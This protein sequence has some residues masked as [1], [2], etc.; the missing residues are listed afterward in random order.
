RI[1][2]T[3]KTAVLRRF[4]A[5][6]AEQGARRPWFLFHVYSFWFSALIVDMDVFMAVVVLLV[7]LVC[8]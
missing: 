5:S 4:Q 7:L 2:S 8:F 6:A 3:H 1:N